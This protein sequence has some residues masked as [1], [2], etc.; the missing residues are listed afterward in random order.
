MF[1]SS[2]VDRGFEILSGQT[3]H[4]IIGICWFSA[5]YVALRSKIK[6]KL[7]R[8]QDNVSVWTFVSVSKRDEIHL[9]V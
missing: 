4:F 1:V 3:T 7:A 2:T 9:L 8:N 5:K 6:D